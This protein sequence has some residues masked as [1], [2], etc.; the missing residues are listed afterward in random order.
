MPAAAPVSGAPVPGAP[1]NPKTS[2]AVFFAADGLRQD[3]I[4][5][6]TGFFSTMNLMLRFG[7]SASGDGLLTQAPPNTGAGWYSLATGAWPGVARLDEQHVPHQ[8][9]TV[10]PNRTAAFDAGVLQAE[11]IAQA[12]ER[13]G[14]KV[15]QV[16]WAGGRNGAIAGP[17]IDF[18]SFLSGR[19]VT[20]NFI[21]KAGEPLFDD[22]PF[23]RSFGLQ[24]DHPA[25]YAGQPP[26]AAAAPTPATGWTGA[27]PQSFS[28]PM[29]MRMRVLDFGDDKYGLNAYIYD[30]T[31]NRRTDYDRVLFSRT[32]DAADKVADLRQGETADVKVKIVGGGLAGLTAGFLVKVEVLVT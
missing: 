30:S 31:N 4:P 21:G 24:F 6:Y 23:I 22:D 19:G 29:E 28:P 13:G 8:R 12:A 10:R 25:G 27:L 1:I 16:E 9:A 2:K 26:F 3:L 11:T 15:A 18:R 14:L 7:T 5:K 20:T 32:K 17:T